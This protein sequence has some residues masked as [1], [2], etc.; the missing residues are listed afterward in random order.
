MHKTRWLARLG[1]ALA[2]SAESAGHRK[3][4]AYLAAATDLADLERRLAVVD[5]PRPW[6][7]AYG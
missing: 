7:P 3:R 1:Q 4:E 2:R 5:R 6:I